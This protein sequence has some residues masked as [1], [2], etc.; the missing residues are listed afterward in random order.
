MNLALYL[1]TVFI[2]GTTWLAIH[3][4]VG[5]VPVLIS[6]F[7][8]FALAGMLFLPLLM[9]L[10]KRQTTSLKDHGFFLLQGACLFS[11]NFICFYYASGYIVSGL[12]SVVFSLA[13]LFNAFNN[14]LIWK[15]KIAPAVIVA[16]L[17]GLAGLIMLFWD[18]ILG[19]S[20]D[21]QTLLGLGLCAVGTFLFSL[22]NMVSVRHTR[23]GLKPWTTNAYAMIY[24]ALILLVCIV[25]T[26]TPWSISRE[27]VYLGSLLYLAIPGSIIGF[28]TYLSLVARLGANQAAYATVM[29]PVVALTISSWVENYQWNTMSFT[30]L[31]L[32]LAG[33]S[34]ALGG[35]QR[36]RQY[37]LR[38]TAART[39]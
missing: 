38:L 23:N 3:F 31:F 27:P 15:Q 22:G 24:G 4:Q 39:G 36:L 17:F 21:R 35:W 25:V 6:I 12:I 32:V 29:F 19:D 11:F 34:I 14:R 2:W 1:T 5:E 16:T 26:G 9:L 10:N 8:R 30:G 20:F 28:T 18:S 33:N 13:T 37:Q 7:Y